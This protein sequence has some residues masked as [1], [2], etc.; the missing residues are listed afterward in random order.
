SDFWTFKHQYEEKAN[1]EV[2]LICQ[3][4]LIS[5]VNEIEEIVQLPV[6]GIWIGY[7]DLAYSMGYYGNFKHPEVQKAIDK[8]IDAA[9]KY[10]KPWGMP[11]ATPED[12]A[13]RIRQGALLMI[14][15]SDSGF[16]SSAASER[17]QQC[18]KAIE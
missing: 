13:K 6:D 16:I 18:R 2:L 10:N 3:I 5:A 15:G 9:N 4:E 1:T 8:V 12:F 11:A 14:S 7:A 17:V